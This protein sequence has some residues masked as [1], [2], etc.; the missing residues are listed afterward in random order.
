MWE[1]MLHFVAP[2]Q[3]SVNIVPDNQEEWLVFSTEQPVCV[4]ENIAVWCVFIDAITRACRISIKHNN[5]KRQNVETS[6][7]KENGFQNGSQIMQLT[8]FHTHILF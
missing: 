8:K 2:L 6:V 7:D 3:P 5:Q 4:D 1:K